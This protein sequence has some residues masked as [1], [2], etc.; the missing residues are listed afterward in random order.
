MALMPK[1]RRPQRRR[2][3]SATRSPWRE[4]ED[5]S[6][7]AYR[8]KGDDGSLHA[9]EIL[10]LKESELETARGEIF[11]VAALYNAAAAVAESAPRIKE[12]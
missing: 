6:S 2:I 7:A 8:P 3:P 10:S 9:L 12:V 1:K 11:N 4:S 5:P